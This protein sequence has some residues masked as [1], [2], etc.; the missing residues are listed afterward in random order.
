M[1]AP[2]FSVI[3]TCYNEEKFIGQTLDSVLAQ[4]KVHLIK[5]IIVADDGSKDSSK[6]AVLQKASEY[7]IIKYVYQ[8]NK[9]LPSARNTAIL[10]SSAEYIAI[11]D[12]DDLWEKNKIEVVAKYIEDYP[13]VA[14]FYSNYYR[15]FYQNNKLLP[16][17]VNAYH[18]D[19]KNLL[20][21]FLSKG[22]PIVPSSVVI[23][24]ECLNDVGLFD[25]EFK[26][27]EDTDLWLRIAVNH[28]FQHINQYLLKKRQVESSLGDNTLENAKYYKMAFDKIEKMVPA[29]KPY[30]RQRDIIIHYKLGL[31]YYHKKEWQNARRES[32][33]A[34]TKKIN[35][36]KAYL[37]LMSAFIK[38]VLR[39]DILKTIKKSKFNFS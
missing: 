25:P 16:H 39:I 10:H 4:T 22:G 26:M 38:P 1:D 28:S 8:E 18:H 3:I 27:A 14:L 31:Y 15:Y 5:E 2:F 13:R 20:P 32:W 6:E 33:K 9:G 21:Q 23:K 35:Y 36:G 24:R 34:I 37:L 11:L 30:R 7:P 19:E 29:V 12:G 17:K